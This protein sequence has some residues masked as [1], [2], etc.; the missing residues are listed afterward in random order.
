[1]F[2]SRVTIMV[3]AK[4]VFA[5]A[6]TIFKRIIIITILNVLLLLRTRSSFHHVFYRNVSYLTFICPFAD[7]RRLYYRCAKFIINL[8]RSANYYY[9]YGTY[10][11]R[12][13]RESWKPRT[14]S[15][16][17]GWEGVK[18]FH[19]H[20]HSRVFKIMSGNQNSKYS[21]LY[22]LHMRNILLKLSRISKFIMPDWFA[23]NR[24]TILNIMGTKVVL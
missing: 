9:R 1:M 13:F 22:T 12:C 3:Y 8:T 5:T 11:E 24:Y 21:I 20:H 7:H 23:T 14:L 19:G 15:T 18:R 17:A 10:I 4:N 2:Y 16:H 6:T